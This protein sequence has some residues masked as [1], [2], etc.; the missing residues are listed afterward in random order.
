MTKAPFTL[1]VPKQQSTSVVFASPHSGR[2]YPW[3]FLRGSVLDEK[4]IRSSEDAF[5]DQ[6]FD[7]VTEYGAPILSAT[8]PRAYIDLNRSAEE[9]DPALIEGVRRGSH[10]P[11]VTSGL[12][13]IPRVV[14]NG[15]AIYRGKISLE[16]AHTRLRDYWRPYHERREPRHALHRSQHPQVSS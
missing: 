4:A 3:S 9:L 7:C 10:N 12:G 13:V 16:E 15:R 2:D 8:A 6:L 1:R 5:V 14:A 11:R